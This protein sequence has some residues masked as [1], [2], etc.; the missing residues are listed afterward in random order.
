MTREQEILGFKIEHDDAATA[1]RGNG[2]IM[3]TC[4]GVAP[5][6]SIWLRR[7]GATWEARQHVA[8]MGGCPEDDECE[9]RSP[10]ADNFTANLARGVGLT[11]EAAIKALVADRKKMA[12]S[13]FGE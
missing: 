10:F 12:D 5:M 11:K 9:G 8:I 13:L 7:R 3:C 6:G 1:L 2:I 4:I